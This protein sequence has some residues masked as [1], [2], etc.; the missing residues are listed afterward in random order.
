MN[1]LGRIFRITYFGESHGQAIG[2]VVDGCPAGLKL[3]EKDI[4]PDLD[5]R[6]AG[7]GPAATARREKDRVEIWSGTMNG[8]TTGAPLCLVIRNEDIDDSN[9]DEL[10][11]LPRP[12][13]ADLAARIRYGGFHDYRGGGIFSGRRTVAYV[14][15]GAVARKLLAGIGI[16]ILGHT[17]KIGGTGVGKAGIDDIRKAAGNA[18]RCADP[19]AAAEMNEA[20]RQ[21]RE[22]GDSLGGIVEVVALNV[23]AGLGEPVFGGLDAE[24]ARAV[25]C[26]PAVKGVEFGAGFGAAEL[27]GSGNNDAYSIVNGAISSATNH[28]G[29]ISGGISNGMPVVLRAA[30]KPTPSI[31]REQKTVDIINMKETVISV[32]GRHDACIV[33]RAVAA[34][35]AMTAVTLCDMAR[36]AGLIPEVLK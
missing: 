36:C 14:M 7:S 15:A 12:G 33:P 25:M 4:Q 2:V 8:F 9:Y 28:A 27:K 17:V 24:L 32:G 3:E 10:K 6:R 16:E 26:I 1:S 20:I 23:P 29:G 18:L 22:E 35:E 5:R 30:V 34:V 13:H 19:A 21:A 11:D 31:A